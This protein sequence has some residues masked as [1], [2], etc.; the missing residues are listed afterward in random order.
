MD[1]EQEMLRLISLI[2]A[3]VIVAV[4]VTSC[5][6]ESV[7]ESMLELCD[8]PRPT[9][10]CVHLSNMQEGFSGSHQELLTPMSQGKVAQRTV[11]QAAKGSNRDAND[12]TTLIKG[13]SAVGTR[14]V[15][16]SENEKGFSCR[17]GSYS[18]RRVRLLGTCQ[19]G[20]QACRCIKAHRLPLLIRV[21]H[22]GWGVA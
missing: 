4:P 10:C 3:L 22:L 17:P 11:P 9:P 12:N 1:V 15:P 18:G 5:S 19:G 6:H 14:Y 20:A 21:K 16:G 7:L 8:K 2:D 13:I